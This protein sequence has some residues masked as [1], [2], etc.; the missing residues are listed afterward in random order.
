MAL[1]SG[2]DLVLYF[3]FYG[4]LAWLTATIFVSL[5]EQGY[6]NF[7]ILNLPILVQ[8]AIMM[9]FLIILS[10]RKNVSTP[11]LLFMT[12]L[13]GIF[14]DKIALFF[15]HK[16]YQNKN[17]PID[18]PKGNLKA[19]T[20][21]SLFLTLLG[22]ILLK[23]FHPILFSVVSLLPLSLLRI[24]ASLLLISL[25]SDIVLLYLLPR[26]YYIKREEIL[27][28]NRKLRLGEWISRG[29]WKR[30]YRQYPS[31][32][33]NGEEDSTENG[34]FPSTGIAASDHFLQQQ[35][36]VFAEGIHFY[37]LIWM[38]LISS[39]MG[40]IIETVYVFLTAHVLMRR[41]S[42]V[43]GPFSLV[44]GLG[45]VILTMVLSKVKK[46]NNF[47]IFIAGFFF[48]GAFE[49]LC[50]VFTEV[51]FGMKFW[52]YSYMP[53]NIDGR[54]N[55]L[56]MFFWGIVSVLWFHYAYP[57]ISRF[58]E[59][60]P[61]ILGS[62]LA[63]AIALFFLSDSMV[64]AMVMIRATDRKKHPEARNVIEKFVDQ[65]YPE[66]VVRTLWPNMNFLSE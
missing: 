24:L 2:T 34:A 60:I 28:Q 25:V 41:S 44:W 47:S 33:T 61:P 45:A 30:I 56:F 27:A 59:K 52:D 19:S 18:F 65:E 51:F 3:F 23:S 57:P 20:I 8:P 21:S 62:V 12:F 22:Y 17:K 9:I 53:F 55:L 15:L 48:G 40:D 54:T 38:L 50:S 35:G 10:S 31:L 7:G 4:F 63:I 32:L 14:V 64:T 26:K 39:F 1:F 16:F 49:Y 6:R 5:K 43:L 29:I 36:I 66:N 42:L 13:Y 58:I 11:G 46:Q 37:K